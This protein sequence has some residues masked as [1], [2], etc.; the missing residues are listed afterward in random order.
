M[1][2]FITNNSYTYM[3]KEPPVIINCPLDIKK[4]AEFGTTYMPVV[5]LVPSAIDQLGS[6]TVTNVSHQPGDQFAVG[7]TTMISY[8]FEDESFNQAICYFSVTV[9][10]GLSCT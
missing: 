7:S 4:S 10:E 2:G 1:S 5:W 8:Y 3:D 9:T 6:V